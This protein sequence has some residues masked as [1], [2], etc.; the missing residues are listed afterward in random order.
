MNTETLKTALQTKTAIAALASVISLAGGAALGA[1]IVTR[2]LT[3]QFEEEL[4]T[5]VQATKRYYSRVYK[6]EKYD[7]PE[8][9]ATEIAEEDPQ[10]KEALTALRSYNGVPL[11][12]EAVVELDTGLVE[13]TQNVFTNARSVQEWDEEKEAES[14]DPERPYVISEDEFLGP[15]TQFDQISLTYFAGGSV[16]ILADDGDAIMDDI[17]ATVGLDNLSRFGHGSNDPNIVYIRNNVRSTD[18]EVAYSKG[19]YGE[20]V[21]GITEDE[22]ELR[23]SDRRPPRRFRSSDD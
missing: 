12:S 1:A 18:Y 4:E 14:R 16:P 21:H 20:L 10:L 22:P 15:E 7:T 6:A 5:Q 9:A 11:S 23:H 8:K 2:K 13:V 17:E 3:A 19:S